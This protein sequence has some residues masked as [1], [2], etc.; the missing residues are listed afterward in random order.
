MMSRISNAVPTGKQGRKV[1]IQDALQAGDGLQKV[2]SE[3][4][5]GQLLLKVA[6]QIEGLPR[7]YST[8]AA[9]VVLSADT[10]CRCSQGLTNAY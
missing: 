8:H 1:S 2:L 6:Q 4:D 3:L 7:N 5:D 10:H 9:G